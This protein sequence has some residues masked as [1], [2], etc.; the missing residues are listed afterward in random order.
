M[1]MM[2]LAAQQYCLYATVHWSRRTTSGAT[3]APDR[4][5]GEGDWRILLRGG[6]FWLGLLDGVDQPVTGYAY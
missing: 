4:G 2:L 5:R 6:S 1:L 3:D